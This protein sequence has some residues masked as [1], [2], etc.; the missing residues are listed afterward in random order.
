MKSNDLGFVRMNTERGRPG[1]LKTR[2]AS[3]HIAAGRL[4]DTRIKPCPSECKPYASG[5][6]AND[7]EIHKLPKDRVRWLSVFDPCALAD[8]Q[9]PA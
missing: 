7:P 1:W 5:G 8:N 3:E 6:N 9:L 4:V 2:R